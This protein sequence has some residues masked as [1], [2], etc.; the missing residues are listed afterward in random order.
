MLPRLYNPS[1]VVST[2]DNNGLGFIKD[3]ISCEV[4]ESTADEYFLES[5]IK[6]DDRLAGYVDVGMLIKAKA[7][8]IDPPQL[9]EINKIVPSTKGKIQLSAQHIKYICF[10]NYVQSDFNNPDDIGTPQ[11]IIDNIFLRLTLPNYFTF[12]SPITAQ[13]TLSFVDAPSKTLGEIFGG[14]E[15]SIKSVFSGDFHYNNF[16]IEFLASRGYD[17]GTRIAFGHNLSDGEQTITNDASYSHIVGYAKISRTDGNGYV[18]LTGDP[19]TVSSGRVFPKVKLIDFTDDMKNF[20]GNTLGITRD[21]ISPSNAKAKLT[22]LTQEKYE[23]D[24]SGIANSDVNIKI[25]YRPELDKLNNVRLCDTVTVVMG[26]NRTF[27]A[28]VSKVKYDSLAERY[29]ML[30]VGEPKPSL[31]SFLKK[32]RR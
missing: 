24:Y 29:K 30:E 28:K 21:T 18:I 13:G 16:L 7:N 15:N 22:A 3:C 2:Y 19:V 14:V 23:A 25:N 32:N 1:T 12:S 6:A 5:T 10:Q 9:F 31:S 4:T 26:N 20:F 17:R 11:Q 8:D 27:K